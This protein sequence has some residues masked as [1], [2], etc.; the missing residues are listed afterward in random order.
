M[1]LNSDEGRTAFVIS[2]GSVEVKVYPLRQTQW[3]VCWYGPAGRV[4]K[5]FAD[6]DEA[7]KYARQ[8]A[9]QLVGQRSH[10]RTLTASESEDFNAAMAILGPLGVSLRT[11]AADYAKRHRTTVRKPIK[12]AVEALLTELSAQGLSVAYQRTAKNSLK[13]F[14][15]DFG[16]SALDDVSGPILRDW[17]RGLGV[18]PKTVQGIRGLVVRLYNFAASQ[19]WIAREHAL[20]IAEVEPPK[21]V[22][23]DSATLTPDELLKLFATATPSEL[24]ALALLSFCPLRTAEV[25]RLDWRDVRL[26]ERVVIINAGIAKLSVRRNAPIPDAA[27]AWLADHAKPSGPVWPDQPDPDGNKLAHRL[28]VIAAAARVKYAKNCLRHSCISAL[29]AT[30]EDAAR[31]S[32]WA[33]NSPRIISQ[34]YSARWTRQQGEAWFARRPAAPTNVVSLEAAA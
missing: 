3:Q 9:A 8:Q 21:V 18:K 16:G 23:S 24:P 25:A 5:T 32:L 6:R 17:L 33:G 13:R 7:A 2:K 11:A 22:V 1:E 31:V 12:E 4:R 26:A 19:R 30:T 29:M 15:E 14:G 27:I 34:T 28:P 20:E 10:V